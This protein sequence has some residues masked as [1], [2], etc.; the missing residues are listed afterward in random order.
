MTNY[1]RIETRDEVQPL[2]VCLGALARVTDGDAYRIRTGILGR[3]E[4][5]HKA[6]AKALTNRRRDQVVVLREHKA[7]SSK[8]H[9]WKD[10]E[11]TEEGGF[12]PGH[13]SFF[14]ERAPLKV[15][16]VVRRGK[17]YN[18]PLRDVKEGEEII[19]EYDQPRAAMHPARTT[20]RFKGSVPAF[21]IWRK[22]NELHPTKD[23]CG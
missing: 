17:K 13:F 4:P 1:R 22:G 12:V 7:V 11:M 23:T 19:G 8:G 20:V 6:I 18:L 10:A 16:T 2:R 14:K 5:E 9:R 21:M 15:V 3:T